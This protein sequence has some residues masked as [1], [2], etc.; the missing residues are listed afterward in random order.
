MGS[1]INLFQ[2]LRDL[3]P[4]P[5][6][7][8]GKV[9]EIHEEDHTSTVESPGPPVY[10]YAGNV[11]VG[12]VLRPR[13]TH[14]PVGHRAFVRSGVIET[15]APSGDIIDIEIGKI[16]LTPPPAAGWPGARRTGPVRS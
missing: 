5:V 8:V 2:R 11:A 3:V 10:D 15:E 1:S 6:V 13:G 12:S 14:V 7:Y 4:L 16:V 9:L